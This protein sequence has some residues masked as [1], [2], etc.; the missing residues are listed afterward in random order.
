MKIS[1]IIKNYY[2]STPFLLALKS[3]AVMLIFVDHFA[4]I[5]SNI[6]L[7]FVVGL[8][9]YDCIIDEGGYLRSLFKKQ[10]IKL[11][12]IHS[13]CLDVVAIN[14]VLMLISTILNLCNCEWSY[15]TLTLI[16]PLY[17]F[18]DNLTG[19][20]VGQAI[21]GISTVHSDTAMRPVRA[22]GRNLF[23]LIWPIE[24]LLFMYLGKRLGDI[25]TKTETVVVNERQRPTN[26][27]LSFILFMIVWGVAICFFRRY[28]ANEVAQFIP[29]TA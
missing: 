25:V 26:I 20:S 7:V 18:K 8:W 1:P 13:F 27:M 24:L 15:Y 2:Y 12:R 4:D 14:F 9:V 19:Q 10:S 29:L 6:L 17:L 5:K 22:L 23:L 11:K 3:T 16:V 21:I 28:C